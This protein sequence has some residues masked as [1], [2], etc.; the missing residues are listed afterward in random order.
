MNDLFWIVN[1]DFNEGLFSCEKHEG[2][3]HEE[4]R[5]EAFRSVLEDYNLM[6]VGYTGIWFT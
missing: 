2:L 4:R 5:M 6:D 3:P 1:G